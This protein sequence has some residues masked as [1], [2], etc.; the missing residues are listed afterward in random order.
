MVTLIER[1]EESIV[2]PEAEEQITSNTELLDDVL[3][4]IVEARIP[5]VST[6]VLCLY[7]RQS[8][9]PPCSQCAGLGNG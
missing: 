6:N 1:E 9:V 3:D 5:R 2:L 8:T 7:D 4:K